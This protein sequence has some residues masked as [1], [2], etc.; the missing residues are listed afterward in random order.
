MELE[1]QLAKLAE[2]G[3]FLNPEITIEDLLC[4]EDR[5]AFVAQPFVLLLFL[6]GSEVERK[7]WGRRIC[8]R[9]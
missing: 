8:N 6:L 9:V 3:L 5:E 7:P 2:L 4:S 1:S